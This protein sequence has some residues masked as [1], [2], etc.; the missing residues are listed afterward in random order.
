MTA[1]AVLSVGTFGLAAI[2]Q[3][4]ESSFNKADGNKDGFVSFEE[5]QVVLSGLSQE[6]FDQ[7]DGNDDAQLDE[8]EFQSLETLAAPQT[9]NTSEPAANTAT[10]QSSSMSSE[11]VNTAPSQ[12]SSESSAVVN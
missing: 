6:L 3:D 4:T 8:G 12:S 11:V 1:A 5:A 7:A 2:A 10:D 9:N